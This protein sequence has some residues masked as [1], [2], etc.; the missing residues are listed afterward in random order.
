MAYGTV[1]VQAEVDVRDVFAKSDDDDFEDELKRRGILPDE[2]LHEALRSAPVQDYPTIVE[3]MLHPKWRSS[4]ACRKQ[5][6]KH[7]GF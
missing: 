3:R 5:Y 2:D 1:Y 6:N 7:M 4:H